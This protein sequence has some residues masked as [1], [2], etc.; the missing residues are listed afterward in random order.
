MERKIHKVHIDKL[1]TLGDNESDSRSEECEE[2]FMIRPPREA[3]AM[4]IWGL[5]Q[6]CDELDS[7]SPYAYLLLCTHF[8]DTSLVV[9][10]G[11]PTGLKQC[12][13]RDD[14]GALVGFVLGYRPPKDPD[15]LFVWQVGVDDAERGQ[16][17]GRQLLDTL[18][19]RC[20]AD[21]G[22]KFLEATVTPSNMASRMLFT[23]FARDRP[24]GMHESV[25]FSS[26]SFPLEE[27]EP[28]EDEVRLRVG[29]IQ[30]ATA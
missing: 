11:R 25:A 12:E 24:A 27:G 30:R 8:A 5:V 20:R 22:A 23:K 15:V 28:H 16:G 14:E 1:Y 26:S 19:D 10:L 4:D 9:R 18:V 3:D 6:S 29:P 21:W 13:G 17:L 2:R 7:N